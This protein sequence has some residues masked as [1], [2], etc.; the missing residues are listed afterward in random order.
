[1][2]NITEKGPFCQSCAIPL[3][4]PDDFG[5]DANGF[6]INDYCQYCFQKGS[7]TDPTITMQQMIDKCI[8]MMV[9]MGVMQ[10]TRVRPLMVAVI[11]GLKRWQGKR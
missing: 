3:K 4:K 11:P 6:R 10:E 2:E 1:M 8:A 7:F 5:T 9:Q